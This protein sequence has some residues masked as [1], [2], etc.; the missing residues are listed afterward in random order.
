MERGA[1]GAERMTARAISRKVSSSAV[2]LTARETGRWPGAL[3]MAK[4]AFVPPM[5]QKRAGWGKINTLPLGD[6]LGS[7]QQSLT[8]NHLSLSSD[9]PRRS[10]KDTISKVGLLNRW[11]TA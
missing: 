9:R 7:V 3:D 10:I 2:L 4:R 8:E 6:G 1:S 11:R 5:S